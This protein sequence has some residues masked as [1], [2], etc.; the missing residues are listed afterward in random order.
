MQDG[1]WSWS[2]WG[3][4]NYPETTGEPKY[5][6][7][8]RTCVLPVKLQSGKFYAIWL[9]SDKFKNFKDV[10]GRPAVPYLLTFFTSEVLSDGV[11]PPKVV[12]I[13]PFNGA[14]NV[15]ATLTEIKV[16]FD[17]PMMDRSWSMTGG[18]A[19]FPEVAGGIRYD[20]KR[21]TWIAPVKLKP[22]W[23]YEFGL[24][25]SNHRNFKSAKGVSLEPIWVTFQTTGEPLRSPD[26]SPKVVSMT[27]VNGATNVDPALTEIKVVFDQPMMDRSWSMTGGG[28]HFPEGAG[29]V[30]YD[31]NRTI[32]IAPVKL[33]PDWRYE[34]GLNSKS[35]RNFK[36]EKG[37]S[38]DPI[39][40]TFTTSGGN[41]AVTEQ[42]VVSATSLQK[43][44]DDQRAVLAWTDRQFRNFFDG[45]TFDGWSDE[46]RTALEKKLIDALSGPRSTE[47]YQA[48]NTLAALRSTS[49]LPRLRAI[50][51][52]RVDRNNRDRWMCVRALGLIGD[53]AA[54]PDLIHLVYH[55]N[56][57]TRWWAQISL[58]RITGKNFGKD[59]NAWGKWWNDQK[60]EPAYKPEIIR[61][62]NG[63]TEPDKLAQTLEESD[64][65]FLESIKPK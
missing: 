29:D 44:N 46:E 38:L 65:K 63:Q 48:I 19:H 47:Y 4:E 17:Q 64:Q 42:E 32:W 55:G 21:M 13:T 35:Y 7:D 50:A 11:L 2:T 34:F 25:S 41:S 54:V 16:V 45:R 1:S 58:V 26:L 8:A 20:V 15:D 31:A 33:K 9:N 57:N 22:G 56:V 12:S 28:A 5:L 51:F 43:L 10:S 36:S 60:G 59:W 49:A 3:E 24:N 61:W 52:E 23:R 18:G 62:W 27:P 14:T 40:V 6:G 37:V 39:W 53:K 30:S